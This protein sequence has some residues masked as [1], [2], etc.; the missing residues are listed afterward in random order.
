MSGRG[1]RECLRGEMWNTRVQGRE[2]EGMGMGI[3]VGRVKRLSP[4]WVWRL[5]WQA[6]LFA[7]LTTFLQSPGITCLHLLFTIPSPRLLPHVT[8][9]GGCQV[10]ADGGCQVTADGGCQVT[11]YGGCQVL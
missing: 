4:E 11:S 3:E 6:L 7:S 10:T 9:D 1:D 8:S 5:C 2:W